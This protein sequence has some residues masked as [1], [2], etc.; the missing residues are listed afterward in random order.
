[1]LDR[2]EAIAKESPFAI[3]YNLLG[4][5]LRRKRFVQFCLSLQVPDETRPQGHQLAL[6]F[7]LP[8]HEICHQDAQ[9][10]DEEEGAM[11]RMACRE[12]LEWNS[13]VY[14]KKQ[15]K[16]TRCIVNNT[17]QHQKNIVEVFGR[18]TTLHNITSFL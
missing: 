15:Q 1:M 3:E 9:S 17:Q 16:I 4:N 12:R 18:W 6:I 2:L 8:A 11:I 14:E 7:D 10:H 5:W 13:Q